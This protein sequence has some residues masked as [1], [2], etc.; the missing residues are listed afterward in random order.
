M[1]ERK[2]RQ[3][4]VTLEVEV[5]LKFKWRLGNEA[6]ADSASRWL[7]FVVCSVCLLLYP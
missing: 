4:K 2:K 6:A 3:Q 5:W 7:G 1:L